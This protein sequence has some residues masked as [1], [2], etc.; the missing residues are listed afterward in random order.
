MGSNAGIAVIAVI[1]DNAGNCQTAT[2][3]RG[4]R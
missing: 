2:A 3:V 4:N 1:A